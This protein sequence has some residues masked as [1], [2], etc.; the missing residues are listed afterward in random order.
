M[1]YLDCICWR[2]VYNF[3]WCLGGFGRLARTAGA[4]LAFEVLNQVWNIISFFAERVQNTAVGGNAVSHGHLLQVGE[5]LRSQVIQ[6]SRQHFGNL[7]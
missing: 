4:E 1:N 3:G 2:L 5:P 7:E 6:N